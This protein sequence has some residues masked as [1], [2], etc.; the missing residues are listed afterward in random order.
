MRTKRTKKKT[1]EKRA[2]KFFVVSHV[3][4]RDLAQDLNGYMEDDGGDSP[5]CL[6]FEPDDQRLTDKVCREYALALGRAADV[7]E[8][9][10]D[11]AE[12]TAEFL[13]DFIVECSKRSEVER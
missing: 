6:R 8:D 1:D 4:R 9:D 7:N 5:R 11:G 10:G 3:R 12:L 2:N 13:H